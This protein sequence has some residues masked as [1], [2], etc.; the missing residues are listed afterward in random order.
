MSF[1][2]ARL[3]ILL[4]FA[5]A[6]GWSDVTRRRISNRL[7]LVCLLVGLALA[8][9]AAGPDSSALAAFGW[10]LASAAVALVVGMVLFAVRAI[11]GGDAKFYAAVAAYFPLQ[12]GLNLGITIA[13]AGGVLLLVWAVWRYATRKRR[14]PG[15]DEGHFA[16]LPY[17]V[18]VGA[19]ALV[20][21][22][23]PLFA[24]IG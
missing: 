21:A 1:E 11:G 23:Y 6:A 4:A 22:G 14:T 19:G 10:H 3:A 17:G 8:P 24:A 7:V 16:R 13:I 2:L 9:F 12:Q 18:A 5:L 20:V 15:M